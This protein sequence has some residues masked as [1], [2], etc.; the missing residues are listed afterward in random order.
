[1]SNGIGMR[2]NDDKSIAMLAAQR[3]IYND[4]KKFKDIFFVISVLIPFCLSII[5]LFFKQYTLDVVSCLLTFVIIV[6]SFLVNKYIDEKKK[7]AAFIQQQFDVYVYTMPWNERIF[8]K[9]KNVNHEIAIKSKKILKN[10]KEKNNLYN[11]YTPTVDSMS[12]YDGI[13][14]CQRE[15]FCWDRDLRKKVLI[16]NKVFILILII[17]ILGMTFL[18]RE[19]L[20][21]FL[22]RCL[23]ITPILEFISNTIIKIKKDINSLEDLDKCIND[24]KIRTMDDLQDIQKKLF[25]H[26]K[27][28]YIISNFVYKMFRDNDEDTFKHE[29]SL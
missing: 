29:A 9:N 18:K 12:L 14:F 17:F 7:L 19:S 28:C 20:I 1:M 11:W 2:Q 4:I 27:G 22:C 10:E 13:L 26:R 15:N 23:L 5:S 3:Q 16:G 25:E 24:D 8:G 21:W 6:L